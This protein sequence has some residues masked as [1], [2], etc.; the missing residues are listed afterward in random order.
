MVLHEILMD[1]NDVILNFYFYLLG[2]WILFL[3]DYDDFDVRNL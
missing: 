1:F 3:I 2:D